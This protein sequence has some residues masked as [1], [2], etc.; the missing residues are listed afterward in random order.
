MLVSH[1]HIFE[2]NERGLQFMIVE[3]CIGSSCHIKGA[4]EVI[5]KFKAF[6]EEKKLEEKIN[7]KACFCMGECGKGVSVRIDGEKIVWLTPDTCDNF[8]ASLTDKISEQ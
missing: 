5:E 2:I 8:F 1:P 3:I 7:L 4:Y 6:I